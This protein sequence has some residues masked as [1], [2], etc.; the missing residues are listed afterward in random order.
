MF[1]K[2]S[3]LVV[4]GL[5]VG[6][7]QANDVAAS[8]ARVAASILVDLASPRARLDSMGSVSSAQSKKQVRFTGPVRKASGQFVRANIL[9][10]RTPARPS[11]VYV[12]GQDDVVVAPV[13]VAKAVEQAHKGYCLAQIRKGQ[14]GWAREVAKKD[15]ELVFG[16]RTMV[17][18][19][20][21]LDRTPNAGFRAVLGF[22]QDGMLGRHMLAVVNKTMQKAKAAEAAEAKQDN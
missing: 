14:V 15:G 1:K 13:V 5:M 21:V 2:L 3:L 9:G 7:A 19:R 11:S 22:K 6:N 12:A 8:P 17:S 20:K 10:Y 16:D 4:L 18:K